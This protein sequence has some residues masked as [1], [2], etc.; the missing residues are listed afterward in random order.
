MNEIVALSLLDL[1]WDNDKSTN[2][3][4][5]NTEVK[6]V[7]YKK[8][9]S[10]L[11][12]FL[13]RSFETYS[14]PKGYLCNIKLDDDANR[15]QVLTR[16]VRVSC[17]CPAFHYWG[18]KYNATQNG[19][20]YRMRTDIPPD[21][22]DP[23]RNHKICKHLVALRRVLARHTQRTLQKRLHSLAEAKV[24]DIPFTE[25]FIHFTDDSVFDALVL[26]YP[27]LA[28]F[29]KEDITDRIFEKLM[30]ASFNVIGI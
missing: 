26:Q 14:S 20:N 17:G 29:E 1:I 30:L 18:A 9:N 2:K 28:E 3:R 12:T 24:T 25:D 7:K 23:D 4:S 6:E 16:D 19:Y 13:V 10:K 21:K 22:R 27:K 15:L 11:F 5:T 8:L